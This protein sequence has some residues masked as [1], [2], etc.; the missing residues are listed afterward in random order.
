VLKYHYRNLFFSGIRFL[1]SMGLFYAIIFVLLAFIGAS[2]IVFHPNKMICI[3]LSLGI[4][5]LIH[6]F[7]KD[8]DF[9]KFH[10]KTSLAV[11]GIDYLIISIP[12]L[13]RLT[14]SKNWLFLS[15]YVFLLILIILTG[16]RFKVLAGTN[17]P[18]H[19]ISSLN[20]VVKSSVRTYFFLYF[21]GFVLLYS[22]V[23]MDSEHL[24][25]GYFYQG[26]LV[27]I[28]FLPSDN[29]NRW[30]IKNFISPISVVQNKLKSVTVNY[31]WVMLLGI[32]P[33]I[34]FY[35]TMVDFAII[36]IAGYLALTSNILF[37]IIFH[38]NKLF[39][40]VSQLINM[41]CIIFIVSVNSIIFFQLLI[42]FICVMA[43]INTLNKRYAW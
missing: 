36:S 31:L 29:E 23:L 43:S 3:S 12:L 28:S 26:L 1:G 6:N 33:F 5:I 11:Y 40:S 41:V 24:M 2:V 18:L 16:T 32:I 25:H 14:D 7:R 21:F 30:Y 15:G 13:Y 4:I 39:L 37:A 34:V 27:L 9:I 19:Y 20:Q 17:I 35:K 38:E 10:I 8:H 22:S 42:L